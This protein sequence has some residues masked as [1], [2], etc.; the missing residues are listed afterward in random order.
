MLR[1]DRELALQ[2]R[3]VRATFR[4]HEHGIPFTTSDGPMSFAT[5]STDVAGSPN[6]LEHSR[7]RGYP[8]STARMLLGLLELSRL[9]DREQPGREVQNSLNGVVSREV[10]RKLLLALQFRDSATVRHSRRVA[11][12]ATGLAQHLGW[13]SGQLRKL[14]IAALLHD[15]GKIGVP[16]NILYKPGALNPD[17]TELFTAYY[18]VG[19]DVLQ[20]CRVE[21]ETRHM[22]DQ[23]QT[24]YSAS[25]EGYRKCGQN[26]PLGSRILAVCDAYESLST[27]KAF[28]DARTHDEI[29]A[30]LEEGSGTLFDG[31]LVAALSR[32][33]KSDGLKLADLGQGVGDSGEGSSTLSA[34]D[35]FEALHISQMFS[36][37]YNL[38]TMYDGLM[39]LDADLRVMVWSRSAEEL[40]GRP[41]SEMLGSSWSPR[42]L[43]YVDQSDEPLPESHSSVRRVLSMARGS[44]S[45]MA[46]MNPDG[47]RRE[48]EVQTLPLLDEHGNLQAIAEIYRDLERTTAKRSHEIHQL[49]LAASRDALTSVANRGE[50]ETQLASLALNYSRSSS[51]IFSV[52]FVDADHFKRINDNYGHGVGDQV[53]ID[54]ARLLQ[55]ETYSGET[56]GR[57]G[58]EEFM[59][60]CPGANLEQAIRR[61]ER[62]RVALHRTRLG[63]SAKLRCT[64][65]FGVAEMEPGDSV[66]SILRRVDEALYQAKEEGRDRTCWRT[67]KDCPKKTSQLVTSST[68]NEPLAFEGQLDVTM[69][70]EL[71]ICKLGSLVDGTGAKLVEVT[72]ERVVMRMGTAGFFGGWGSQPEKQPVEVVLKLVPFVDS[73]GNRIEQRRSELTLVITPLGRCSSPALFETRAKSVLRQFRSYF[74]A[75]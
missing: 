6:A 51:E 19:S 55:E 14:E 18:H 59:V 74:A 58:G 44:T 40:F 72:P 15:I 22:V 52:I 37:L 69:N 27:P 7:E 32:W 56:I 36:Y 43:N 63:G 65:S 20:A 23:S 50:L 39:L 38:E 31:N 8:F 70:P 62:L 57:Y 48:I 46:F 11:L 29:I 66:E 68:A 45:R 17:E 4:G 47:R 35:F 42:L 75:E 49:K 16:D 30:I 13:E 10:L 24:R 33:T 9:A 34:D 64:A 71:L 21:E 28:R 41:A 54:L 5:D 53:L 12:L 25:H 26:V 60:L 67:A 73:R 1:D 2:E 3:G 61:A